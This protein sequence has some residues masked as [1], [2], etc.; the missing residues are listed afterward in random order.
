MH[1]FLL[2]FFDAGFGRG[3]KLKNLQ[4]KNAT[5]NAGTLHHKPVNI[6]SLGI[7]ETPQGE[8]FI[9]LDGTIGGQAFNGQI[10]IESIGSRSNPKYKFG[11]EGAFE[12]N[13]DSIKI[14]GIMRPRTLGGVHIRDLVITNNEQPV[15]TATFSLIREGSGNIDVKGDFTLDEQGSTGSFEWGAIAENNMQINGSVSAADIYAQDFN[16][17]ARLNKTLAKWN[18]IFA[19]PDTSKDVIHNIT[20]NAERFYNQSNVIEN[21]QGK[22][23]ITDTQ[24]TVTQEVDE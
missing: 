19:N 1:L 22:V 12:F 13:I 6:K 15:L 24:I 14:T 8:P 18:A 21:Y 16:E 10:T 4:I 23:N 9:G 20:L 7:D 11:E 5:F 17:G 2:V 3:R